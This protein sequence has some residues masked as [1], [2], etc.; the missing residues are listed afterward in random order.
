[1]FP[2]FPHGLRKP[3][4]L[5]GAHLGTTSSSHPVAKG[6]CPFPSASAALSG[7]QR[8]TAFPRRCPTATVPV[9]LL[10][11]SLALLLPASAA[12]EVRWP[13][14]TVA[15]PFSSWAAYSAMPLPPGDVAVVIGRCPLDVGGVEASACTGPGQPIYLEPSRLEGQ[16]REVFLHELGHQFDFRV[17]TNA[18]RMRLAAAMHAPLPWWNGAQPSGLGVVRG[19]IRDVCPAGADAGALAP[20]LRA[21]VAPLRLAADRSAPDAHLLSH[22]EDLARPDGERH[23]R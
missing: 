13:S 20:P 16:M 1:M 14:G 8:V 12:A 5:R 7:P 17:L 4:W 21:G 2:R 18:D 11:L 23:Q 15:Q 22:L 6:D 9:C 10:G 3:R 19:G